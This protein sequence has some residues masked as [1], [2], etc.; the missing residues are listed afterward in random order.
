MNDPILTGCLVHWTSFRSI[1]EWFG[2]PFPIQAKTHY[3]SCV[4]QRTVVTIY[5]T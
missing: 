5:E 1:N 2:L 4:E 3:V